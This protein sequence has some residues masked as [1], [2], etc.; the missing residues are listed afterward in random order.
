M[1]TRILLMMVAVIGLLTTAQAQF[2]PQN[3]GAGGQSFL[4]DISCT[5]ATHCYTTGN[6]LLFKTIDGTTWI[7][8]KGDLPNG[9]PSTQIICFDANACL[10]TGNAGIYKTINGGLN[11]TVINP[12]ITVNLNFVS[13]QIGF[14]NIAGSDIVKTTDGGEN[15]SIINSP[16]SGGR[17]YFLDE[18]FGYAVSGAQQGFANQIYRTTNGGL[19]WTLVSDD[20]ANIGY[21]ILKMHVSS[22]NVAYAVGNKGTILRTSDGGDNWERLNNP[23]I[24]S[25]SFEDVAFIDENSGYV[26]G[27]Q[28]AILK[29]NDGGDT[30]INESY[31]NN[32]IMKSVS[33][34]D[35]NTV[36][37]VTTSP[38]PQYLLLKNS[39]AGLLSVQELNSG[40][41][42]GS[43]YP[44]PV[45]EKLVINLNEER[46]DRVF[47]IIDLTGKKVTSYKLTQRE[48]IIEGIEITNGTY[49]YQIKETNVIISTGKI[50]FN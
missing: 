6:N 43:I 33:I 42:I 16:S 8:A 3:T 24:D 37:V 45:T 49:I 15:W 17:P 44:N 30:W 12:T 10:V 50:N 25:N 23:F 32:H 19:N 29:T 9:E 35:L 36:Y 46:N 5:D 1:K 7:S 27:S 40:V 14:G 11:W 38:L 34:A 48:T 18:N 20:T 26:V 4:S 28:S 2:V 47:E 41:E 31:I 39:N 21:A 22:T 13:N